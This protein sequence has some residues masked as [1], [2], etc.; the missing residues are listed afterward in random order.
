M[1]KQSQ[2]G[3][4]GLSVFFSLLLVFVCLESAA[5]N[6]IPKDIFLEQRRGFRREEKFYISWR[7]E[8]AQQ[9][10][11]EKAITDGRVYEA[12][13]RTPRE[14]FIRQQNL[15]RAYEDSWMPIGYGVTITDPYTVCMMT[16]TI[17]PTENMKVLEI[18]TGTGYQAALLSHLTNQVY[19]IEI[20]KPL[21]L[22]T[23]AII[24]AMESDYTNYK[25]IHCKIADGYYGWAEQAPFDRIIVTCGID[26]IPPLLIQQLKPDGIMV[27][28]VGPPGDMVLLKVTKQLS[29][30][31]Q[32][33]V[34]REALFKVTF[35]PFK[36]DKGGVHT[37]AAP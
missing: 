36:N 24:T 34:K 4:K 2:P 12:F 3:R 11:K 17:L 15:K 33:I 28:P 25:N 20:I 21:A 27:I 1:N 14:H 26:H 18:G 7:W 32:V 9:L 10:L 35:V 16:E 37:Q 19:T 6:P 5:I 29:R 8:L 23:Q 31:G 30:S 22:E 13:L